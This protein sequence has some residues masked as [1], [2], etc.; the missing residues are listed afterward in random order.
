MCLYGFAGFGGDCRSTGSDFWRIAVVIRGVVSCA[1][2][3]CEFRVELAMIGRDGRVSESRSVCLR[4]MDFEGSFRHVLRP[5]VQGRGWE[6][7]CCVV[8]CLP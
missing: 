4:D 3:S 7:I 8:N 2:G 1:G 6:E 5:Y